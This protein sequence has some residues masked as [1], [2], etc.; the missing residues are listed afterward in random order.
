VVSRSVEDGWPAG[1]FC[2]AGFFFGRIFFGDVCLAPR[3]SDERGVFAF[4]PMFPDTSRVVSG[5]SSP[6]GID[7][8]D[9]RSCHRIANVLID[10]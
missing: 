9:Q 4:V 1:Q 8:P 3:F 5:Q 2:P 7:E 10:R 6:S